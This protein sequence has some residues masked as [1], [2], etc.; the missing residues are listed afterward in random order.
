MAKATKG[1]EIFLFKKKTNEFFFKSIS[2]NKCNYTNLINK[3][4]SLPNGTLTLDEDLIEH[5][6][7]ISNNIPRSSIPLV[8]RSY[9]SKQIQN[10]NNR[11]KLSLDYIHRLIEQ[12]ERR[13]EQQEH[14]TVIEQEWQ[15]LGRVTDRLLVVIFFIGTMLAFVFIFYQAPHLRLK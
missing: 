13:C 9:P 12:N 2:S 6:K 7:T 14:N 8:I 11:L 1:K 4:N 5:D 10:E 3:N 15:I